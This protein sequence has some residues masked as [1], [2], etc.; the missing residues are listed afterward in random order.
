MRRVTIAVLALFVVSLCLGS[1]YRLAP[2]AQ[3]SRPPQKAHILDGDFSIQKDVHRLPDTLK[4]AFAHLAGEQ[5]F[6][7]ANPGERFQ[8]ADVI[9]E[10]RLP[11]RRLLFAGI[12]KDKYFIHYER[13][14][15]GH[16]Y[17]IAVFK[18]DPKEEV[19]FLWGSSGATGAKNLEQLRNMVAMREFAD[20]QGHYW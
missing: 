15:R 4:S 20:D 7:M 17:H 14:G 10:P 2:A 12:S 19:K 11:L 5:N 1:P 3:Q 13:G 9:V 8:V 6:E 18:V 16:S